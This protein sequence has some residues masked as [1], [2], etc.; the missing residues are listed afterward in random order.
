MPLSSPIFHKHTLSD[1]STK[2]LEV[3][4]FPEFL[5]AA[6]MLCGSRLLNIST[7]HTG[8]CPLMKETL[9]FLLVHPQFLFF[10]L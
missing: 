3:I 1:S 8:D 2:A 5:V 6:Q 4:R 9:A 7:F 10:V